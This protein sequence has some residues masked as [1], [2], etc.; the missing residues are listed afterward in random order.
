MK[1]KKYIK[2]LIKELKEGNSPI[3]EHD[4]DEFSI[5]SFLQWVN[6]YRSPPEMMKMRETFPHFDEYRKLAFDI[7]D[8]L[9]NK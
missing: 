9:N 5:L 7:V 1:Q 8:Q 6:K 2:K 4:H 3:F